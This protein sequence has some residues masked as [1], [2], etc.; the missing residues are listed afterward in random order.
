MSHPV[1][2]IAR[3]TLSNMLRTM[4]QNRPLGEALVYPAFAFG[5]QEVRL[6]FSELDSLVGSIAKG[7]IAQGI[8]AGEHV[9]IWGTNVPDWVPLQFALARVGAVLVTVNTALRKEEVAYVLQQ[10]KSVAII[11]TTSTGTNSPS[12]ILDDLFAE[13]HPAV[14]QIRRR[15]W[16]PA[17]PSDSPP[18]TLATVSGT[19]KKGR[20]VFDA[21]LATRE[22]H[23]DSGDVVNIQYTSGTTGFPKGV[24]LS[25]DNLMHSA[26]SIAQQINTQ[27]EDRLAMIL[28]LF[29][30]FG[31]VVCVLGA[32]SHGATLCVIP[33]FNPEDALRLVHE[34]RCTI[35]HGVPTMFS[36]MLAHPERHRFDTSCLEKGLAAGSPVPEPL[37]ARI[38]DELKC[39]G[40]SIA[41][42]LTEAAPG[43]AGTRPSDPLEVR[44]ST[45]GQPLPGVEVN[46]V[47]PATG[48]AV[49]DG[50]RGELLC[51][52][53]N[54]M[55][56][57]HDD[58]EATKEAVTQDGWLKTGD[59]ALR[60]QDGNLS[61][62]G[63]I[64]DIIIRG[65]E[66][67]APAEVESLLIEH[68]DLADASVVGI[69]D[70]HLGEEVACAVL[71]KKD[72]QFNPEA[73]ASY[74]EDRLSFFKIPK[75]WK[76]LEA[77]PLTGSGK[78]KKFLLREMLSEPLEE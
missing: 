75:V 71:L 16:M 77:F 12:A 22:A 76:A 69:P 56:G 15:I 20:S 68:P 13:A 57:Y 43:V 64:K 61:I 38:I 63:R 72:V 70:E 3:G 47:D 51:R 39:E 50:Q 30:C 28:P 74:L 6:T 48:K 33:S 24:M 58:D 65:G 34:E 18:G 19:V 73:Y 10:S 60:R 4:A 17:N 49:P 36:A 9:A 26:W 8:Q 27:P 52:G 44:C 7:L 53:V 40:M 11:H 23:I 2:P 62:V 32:Y 5:G 41:Y 31:C 14:S 67:V 29:H 21:D 1:Q 37:M 54:V 66:N 25:H 55:V 46:I 45:I 42:G 35:L 59:E 78:V